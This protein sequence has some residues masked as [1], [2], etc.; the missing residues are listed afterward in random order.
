MQDASKHVPQDHSH[1]QRVI[2]LLVLAHSDGLSLAESRS[3]L[4]DLAQ[5]TLIDALACLQT[6][7]VI[8]VDQ[9]QVQ[10]SRCARYLDALLLICI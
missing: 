5:D 10:A 9:E 4:Y 3:E 1:A 7:G 2:V 6:E 8:V